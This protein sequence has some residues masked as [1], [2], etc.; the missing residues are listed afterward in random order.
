MQ[1]STLRSSHAG[2]GTEYLERIGSH[3]DLGLERLQDVQWELSENEARY[4]ALLD[5]QENAIVRRDAAGN[6]TFANRAF[7][8]MF[9]ASGGDVIGKPFLIEVCEKGD[10]APLAV[11]DDIRQQRF[12]QHALT[13]KG[14]RWIE[15]EEQLVAAPGGGDFEVQSVGRDVDRAAA[16]RNAVGRGARSGGIGQ[17]RQ[18]RASS[19]P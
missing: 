6:L 8:D 16:R 4:R 14:P 17:S 15:W 13:A 5:T 18:E 2:A 3:I 9:G 1:P 11:S 7:L 19:P 10:I 12:V